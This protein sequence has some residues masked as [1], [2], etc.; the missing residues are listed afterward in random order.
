MAATQRLS[1]GVITVG[2]E[3]CQKVYVATIDHRLSVDP[4]GEGECGLDV[5]LDAEQIR[6]RAHTTEDPDLIVRYARVERESCQHGLQD[7]VPVLTV[8]DRDDRDARPEQPDSV[9]HHVPDGAQFV[10]EHHRCG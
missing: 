7:G 6:H 3:T 4:V 1:T 2:R 10:G 8:R 5:E 9:D